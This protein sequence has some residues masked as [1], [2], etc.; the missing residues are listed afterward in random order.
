VKVSESSYVREVCTDELVL[1]NQIE[2]RLYHDIVFV[3]QDRGNLV[4]DPFLHQIN[5]DLL[6]VDFLVELGREFGRLEAFLIDTERHV[7]GVETVVAMFGWA[8]TQE[9]ESW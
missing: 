4:R 2:A 6:N 5:V 9:C 7:C 8:G 1:L 3:A